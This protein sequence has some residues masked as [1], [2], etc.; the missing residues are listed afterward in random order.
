MA[1]FIGAEV[2]G[3][4]LSLDLLAD[5]DI[6]GLLWRLGEEADSK[7]PPAAAALE[8]QGASNGAEA[9]GLESFGQWLALETHGHPFYLVETL[10][11]L[12]EEKA[13]NTKPCR[14]GDCRGGRACLANR[15]ERL[16]RTAA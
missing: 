9:H 8:E 10:K 14:R 2:A 3:G 6:E 11:A 15:K 5:E 12:L 13:P 16:E 7:P 4:S 1:L